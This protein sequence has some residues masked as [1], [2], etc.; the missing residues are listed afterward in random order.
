MTP[1]PTIRKEQP[2]DEDAIFRVTE[3]AFRDHPVS[4]GTESF[5]V[6][7]LRRAGALTLSLVAEKD[8]RV[9]GHVAFSPVEIADGSRDWY[10]LGPISVL[11]ELQREG[12]GKALMNGGLE[13]LRNLGA[14]GCF[15]VGPPGYYGRFGFRHHPAVTMEGVPPE[16]VL[17]LPLGGPPPAGEV[18]HHA[19]FG[20]TN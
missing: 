10:A 20:A 13:A 15:L 12:I 2:G 4:Q 19:A 8:G 3:L 11:P 9:A 16:V 5:I 17:I 7:G 6:N 14:G 1:N 18:T